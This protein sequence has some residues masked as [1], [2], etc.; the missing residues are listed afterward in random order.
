MHCIRKRVVRKLWEIIH[1]VCM[2]MV[3]GIENAAREIALWPAEP[4]APLP[5]P[6]EGG[7]LRRTRFS[8]CNEN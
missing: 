2:C 4:L 3:N 5:F 8:L 6:M 7:K 1:H